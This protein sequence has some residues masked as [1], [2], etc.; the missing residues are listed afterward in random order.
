MN[1]VF[2]DFSSNT[3]NAPQV[4]SPSYATGLQPGHINLLYDNAYAP[5]AN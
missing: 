5:P 4:T 1:S 2:K 3:R